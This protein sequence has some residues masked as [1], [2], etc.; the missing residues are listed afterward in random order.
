MGLF[1]LH[2]Y[3][4]VREVKLSKEYKF[5]YENFIFSTQSTLYLLLEENNSVIDALT[6]SKS[7]LHKYG[8]PNDELEHPL[9]KYG[10]GVY[11]LFEVDNSEWIAEIKRK[12]MSHP[13]YFDGLYNNTKHY[14]ARF[15]DVTLEVLSADYK[16]MQINKADFINIINKEIDY[17]KVD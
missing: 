15:K 7:L 11:G 16:L 8:H 4:A 2:K 17:L 9:S 14:V 6:F 3:P 12:G 13:K 10:L 5:M 1:T